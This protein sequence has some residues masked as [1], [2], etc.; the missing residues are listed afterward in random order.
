MSIGM[1]AK[2]NTQ[3][4]RLDLSQAGNAFNVLRAVNG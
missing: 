3:T 4:L 1:F 2:K